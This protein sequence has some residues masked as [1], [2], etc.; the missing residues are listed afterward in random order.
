MYLYRPD[1]PSNLTSIPSEIEFNHIHDT[2]LSRPSRHWFAPTGGN[3]G[4]II[5][6][7]RNVRS[8]D[9]DFDHQNHG[10]EI[11]NSYRVHIHEELLGTPSPESHGAGTGQYIENA[12]LF[13][14][15][16][17]AKSNL[18]GANPKAFQPTSSLGGIDWAVLV[19]DATD[20]KKIRFSHLS[21]SASAQAAW[22]EHT[23][24]SSISSGSKI[25]CLAGKLGSVI[26]W[27]DKEDNDRYLLRITA[28]DNFNNVRWA[29]T[30]ERTRGNNEF[31]D[32]LG[33]TRYNITFPRND[34]DWT[35]IG[36]NIGLT[37]DESGNIYVT[38]NWIAEDKPGGHALF[39]YKITYQGELI[40]K[41]RY[42]LTA[43]AADAEKYQDKTMN[44]IGNSSI[45]DT[46]TSPDSLLTVVVRPLNRKPYGRI[47][48]LRTHL[49][50]GALITAHEM[51]IGG[52]TQYG[53]S[54][55]GWTVVDRYYP[56]TPELVTPLHMVLNGI[57]LS[58]SASHNYSNLFT[59]KGSDN[60]D[61][62]INKTQP[63]MIRFTY[64]LSNLQCEQCQ[65]VKASD[66]NSSADDFDLIM[67]DAYGVTANHYGNNGE[68]RN[69]M[70]KTSLNGVVKFPFILG[71]PTGTFHDAY[72]DRNRSI[73]TRDDEEQYYCQ[74]YNNEVVNIGTAY[75]A[76]TNLQNTFG[77]AR[78]FGSD[79][80]EDLIEDTAYPNPSYV[81]TWLVSKPQWTSVDSDVNAR[82]SPS[83]FPRTTSAYG[84]F[85]NVSNWYRSNWGY[86]GFNWP[87]SSTRASIYG[88]VEKPYDSEWRV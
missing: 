80:V 15:R 78:P 86:F 62:R 63:M 47:T 82:R 60:R 61:G 13:E 57:N 71:L 76:G 69:I 55:T 17:A 37:Y 67:T 84:T 79:D 83:T 81:P 1:N 12:N 6:G 72:I 52:G 33:A 31:T 59:Y 53:T 54:G 3:C 18:G 7:M 51:T 20:N 25:L 36:E 26:A 19:G 14:T 65:T 68:Q 28:F 39:I 22:K 35:R 46:S 70:I 56:F 11:D 34:Q 8:S 58:T 40:W 88:R 4:F 44:I 45:I 27:R 32:D 73:A 75:P 41:R 87:N 2:Y 74:I 50:D 16:I 30:L 49:T 10:T 48:L 42:S 66:Y 64:S 9:P 23:R 43:A 5:A 21:R 77:L 29:H 38:T 24:Y 85:S